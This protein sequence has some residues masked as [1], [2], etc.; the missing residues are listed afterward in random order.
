[1]DKSG[2][3]VPCKYVYFFIHLFI[4]LFIYLFISSPEPTARDELIGW[5]SSRHPPDRAFTLSNI[6]ISKTS[7]PIV[8]KFYL[9]HRC[10]G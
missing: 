9:E 3:V 1:M 8:I 7:R 2:N 4:Y 10:D 6:N 5:D